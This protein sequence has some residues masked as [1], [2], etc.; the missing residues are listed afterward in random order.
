MLF[1]LAFTITSV[2]YN[3]RN[4]AAVKLVMK[5]SQ[6]CKIG[7]QGEKGRVEEGLIYALP[8]SQA[9]ERQRFDFEFGELASCSVSLYR[10]GPNHDLISD[11]VHWELLDVDKS[12][13]QC[14]LSE[15]QNEWFWNNLKSKS[16]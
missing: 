4:S 12:T 7:T 16:H 2:Q 3:A 5:T 15:M 13:R 10:D 6:R 9:I 14:K 11:G 8:H 1:K